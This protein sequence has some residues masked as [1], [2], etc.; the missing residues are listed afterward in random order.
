MHHLRRVAIAFDARATRRQSVSIS[1]STHLAGRTPPR[2]RKR[3]HLQRQAL[4]PH[5]R[6]C[7]GPSAFAKAARRP[8][9]A[10]SHESC[11]DSTCRAQAVAVSAYRPLGGRETQAVCTGRGARRV[12][13]SQTRRA[14]EVDMSK[15][16][17]CRASWA[18]RVLCILCP[19]PSVPADA[20]YKPNC[21]EAKAF[22]SLR[23]RKQ[24]VITAG[25]SARQPARGA[26][27]RR[28]RRSLTAS[29]IVFVPGAGAADR[30]TAP[31]LPP[32]L[33]ADLHPSPQPP[34]PRDPHAPLR[35]C[36]PAA[37]NIAIRRSILSTG[38]S[39]RGQRRRE[40][41]RYAHVC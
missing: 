31:R 39:R 7:S 5:R 37:S 34:L 33:A 21:E 24:G 22:T 36:M 12:A 14:R 17:Q 11:A 2:T 19:A 28:T 27:R 32:G 18:P 13:Q 40:H 6:L 23:V 38:G 1:S 25:T 8:N 10:A 20:P 30:S 4:I 29:D 15:T 26:L 16:K 41:K 35:S 3:F 9:T